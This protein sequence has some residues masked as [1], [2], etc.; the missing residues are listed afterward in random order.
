MTKRAQPAAALLHVDD[1]L[2]VVDKPPGVLSVPGRG[3]AESLPVLLRGLGQFAD[4]EPLR[5]VHRLDKD[6]SGVLLYA[7]TLEAQRHLVA[8][9]MDRTVA[10]VYFALV[11][12]Y[13]VADGEVDLRLYFHQ[14]QSRVKASD[15][16]GK[17]A[18][19]RYR[20]LERVA[21]HSWLEVR[22][23]TGRMHQIRA[24]L[25]S[26]G[27]PLAVDPTYGGAE[28]VF[29]SRYKPSY[30]PNRR[31][32]EKP[33]IARLSLHAAALEIEHPTRRERMRFEAPLPKDLRAALR[34]LGRVG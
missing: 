16:R 6:A 8:Q 23:L 17:P 24:H 29:L 18:V 14:K 2:V 19:T 26:I 15:R 4:D 31:G 21:G 7:R 13:V 32:E 22:P 1:D 9:F 34:Q 28:A 30:R 10:K 3:A 27:H 12:G 33:L 11:R 5:V 20:V 25:S